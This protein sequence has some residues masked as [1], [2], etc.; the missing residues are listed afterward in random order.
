M[1]V[2]DTCCQTATMTSMHGVAALQCLAAWGE[3]QLGNAIPDPLEEA[4]Q[5]EAM[6]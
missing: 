2:I 1:E 3:R 6:P 4:G 5:R